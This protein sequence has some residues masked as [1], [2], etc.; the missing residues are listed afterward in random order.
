MDIIGTSVSGIATRLHVPSLRLTFDIGECPHALVSDIET[1]CI[2]HGH[3]DHTAAAP[4]LAAMRALGN[5]KA[6]TFYVP[7]HMADDFKALM[8]ISGRLDGEPIPH[9]IVP[10]TPGVALPVRKGLTLHAYPMAHRV[11]SVA[12]GVW[13]DVKRLRPEYA[14]LP[15]AELGRLRKEGMILDDLVNVFSFAYTGDTTAEGLDQN[16]A[17]YTAKTLAIEATFMGGEQSRDQARLKG[18]LHFADILDRA[19]QFKNDEIVFVHHSA[20]YE[21]HN[22]QACLD[23]LPD[24][25]RQRCRWL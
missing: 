4:Y 14:G 6:P 17:L 19:D 3:M 12:Y 2:T 13:Q 9:L 24:T 18:H 23:T 21:P 20:R 7:S 22:L 10:V 25:L 5:M 8:D 11:R 15:G 16:P 1:V